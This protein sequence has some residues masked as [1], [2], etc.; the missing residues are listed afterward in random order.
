MCHKYILIFCFI[1]L[2]VFKPYYIEGQ[3]FYNKS[4]VFTAIDSFESN[5]NSLLNKQN[6]LFENKGSTA[7]ST[8]I[9]FDTKY[10][11][12]FLGSLILKSKHQIRNNSNKSTHNLSEF[13]LRKTIKNDFFIEIG[14]RNIVNG[15]S[16]SESLVDFFSSISP[17]EEDVYNFER[18]K[19]ER[20]GALLLK[21][22]FLFGQGFINATISPKLSEGIINNNSLSRKLLNNNSKDRLLISSGL[23]DF[24]DTT[25]EFYYY[26]NGGLNNF[27]I[28]TSYAYDSLVFN[29]ET[30]ISNESNIKSLEYLPNQDQ[31]NTTLKDSYYFSS[32]FGINYISAD[33]L[34]VNLEYKYYAKGYSALEWSRLYEAL[35]YV[36]LES[37][38][39]RDILAEANEIYGARQKLSSQYLFLYLSKFDFLIEKLTP[40]G[41]IEINLYDCSYSFNMAMTY[42]FSDNLRARC[43]WTGFRGNE[44]SENG[45]SLTK[46]TYYMALNY[47]L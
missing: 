22:E 37:N 15:F 6:I 2:I 10:D 34:T 26:N 44:K 19:N 47:F 39:H 43:S 3:V 8:G 23:N 38:S 5:N 36:Y 30:S 11:N 27:C 21:T 28:A 31:L 40:S 12:N 25:P 32:I 14:K 16:F 13:Y 42:D 18:N 35:D 24:Y 7:Y 17:L 46:N 29:L 20:E 4:Y 41:F 9:F 45:L 1:S 33:L